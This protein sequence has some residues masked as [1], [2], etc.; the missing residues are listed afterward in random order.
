[1]TE[2][3]TVPDTPLFTWVLLPLF[4]LVARAVDVGL[5]T[6]RIVFIAQGRRLQAAMIG[7]FEALI[8][9]AVIGQIL[10]NL[11]NPLCVLAYAA[12]FAIGNL[13]GLSIEQRLAMGMQV[14]RVITPPPAAPL[15]E[16]L[17]R[18]GFGATIVEA[19]GARGPV[20]ILFT[21]VRR[22]DVPLV[23]GLARRHD[24]DGFVSVE[25]VRS[26][27]L[28]TI[29]ERPRFGGPSRWQ[30]WRGLRKRK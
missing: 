19:R 10:H 25:D 28:G 3:F 4:I 29:R 7:F 23:L 6:I 17:G 14:V 21:V 24:P 16:A 1:M 9:L 30:L 22:S 18:R 26:A 8:W 11:R 5:S 27:A 2:L 13:L 15:V 12:G 20:E